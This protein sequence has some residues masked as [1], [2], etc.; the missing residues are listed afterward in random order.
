MA[1]PLTAPSTVRRAMSRGWGR[2]T[3]SPCGRCASLCASYGVFLE[4]AMA[5]MTPSSRAA[6]ATTPARHLPDRWRRLQ[7]PPI[8]SD[9]VCAFGGG[10]GW[11]WAAALTA[12][13]QSGRSSVPCTV[14][15]AFLPDGRPLARGLID[16]IRKEARCD[17]PALSSPRNG[18]ICL[19]SSSLRNRSIM[20]SSYLRLLSRLAPRSRPT[21]LKPRRSYK[22]L[23]V[24]L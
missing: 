19:G 3:R 4:A 14:F 23:A 9:K 18:A 24:S 8:A 6:P 17:Q 1:G 22:R 7:S 21:S 2:R 20:I 12:P 13:E 10:V 11:R 15:D 5:T 16:P